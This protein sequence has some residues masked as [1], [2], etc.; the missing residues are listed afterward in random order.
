[1]GNIPWSCVAK[2]INFNYTK[3]RISIKDRG[4]VMFD[5]IIIGAGVTVSY[6]GILVFL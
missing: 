6:V 2:Q 3:Y 1:M 4:Q 5:V